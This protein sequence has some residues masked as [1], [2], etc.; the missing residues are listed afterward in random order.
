M[1]PARYQRS[2][3]PE[4]HVELEPNPGYL[5]VLKVCVPYGRYA[6]DGVEAELFELRV[7]VVRHER[8]PS[9]GELGERWHLAEFDGGPLTAHRRQQVADA[10]RESIRRRLSSPGIVKAPRLGQNTSQP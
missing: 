6:L 10:V 8:F 7:Q 1:H 2:A 5:A 4:P 9:S 3:P